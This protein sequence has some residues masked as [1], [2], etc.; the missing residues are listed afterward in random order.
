MS[1]RKLVR[2]IGYNKQLQFLL[3]I[4]DTMN[5]N[6]SIF[7]CWFD[8]ARKFHFSQSIYANL[9]STCWQIPCLHTGIIW[10]SFRKKLKKNVVTCEFNKKE[11]CYLWTQQIR[12]LLPVNPTNKK[13]VVNCEFNNKNAKK[14]AVTCEATNKNAVT[15]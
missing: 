3:V 6:I 8:F 14:N 13:N 5:N 7:H 9:V 4:I 15:C 12:M 10:W 1:L 2:I 11:R